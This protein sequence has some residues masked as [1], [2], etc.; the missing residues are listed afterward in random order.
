MVNSPK[1]LA[2]LSI[3]PP[4]RGDEALLRLAQTRL[5]EAGLGGEFYP[6]SPEHLVTLMAYRPPG[7]A[8]TAHLPRDIDLSS[9]AGQALVGDYAACAAGALYGI[10]VHDQKAFATDPQAVF[11]AFEAVERR[12]GRIPN[13]PLLFVEYAAGLPLELFAHLFERTAALQRVCAAVDVSH[14]GIYLCRQLYAAQHRGDDVCALRPDSPELGERI[15]AVQAAVR[16]AQPAV[17]ELVQRLARLRKPLHLHLHDGHPLS[18]LSAF[19]VS[20]HLSFL[21]HIRIPFA[22]GGQHI[23]GGIF[24]VAGLRALMAAALAELAPD[25][26]SC[27]LEIHPQEGRSP[28]GEHGHLFHHW[29]DTYFAEC[30]NYWLDRLID[31]GVL[32]RD[33]CAQP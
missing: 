23:L 1:L 10:L 9:E 19:G 14:V 2:M 11:S 20:D 18:T 16:Q 33:A 28:L 25:H 5:A 4:L 3:Q 31:N 30:M 21:Q 22:Y 6:G 26:L 7:Q 13:A 27:M 29:E 32:L 15:G 17:V 8:C 12:L 24:G